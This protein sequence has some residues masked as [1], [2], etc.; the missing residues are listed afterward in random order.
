MKVGDKVIFSGT[1]KELRKFCLDKESMDIDLAEIQTVEKIGQ[2]KFGSK[3]LW[4]QGSIYQFV[5]GL[6]EVL[7]EKEFKVELQFYVKKDNKQPVTTDVYT[8][9]LTRKEAIQ[10]ANKVGIKKIEKLARLSQEI[11]GTKIICSYRI[12]E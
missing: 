11:F 8:M 12:S 3:T 6:F 5:P 9:A 2:G 7:E 4:I 1:K 10:E